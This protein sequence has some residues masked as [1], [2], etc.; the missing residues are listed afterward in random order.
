[1]VLLQVEV[2]TKTRDWWYSLKAW[3]EVVSQQV[4]L[5]RDLPE[6]L[7][8]IDNTRAW[9]WDGR[10]GH[11]LPIASSITLEMDGGVVLDALSWKAILD[12]AA[13]SRRPPVTHLFLSSTRQALHEQRARVAV[14]D[15]ATAA[16]I[17]LST[18]LDQ[19]LSASPGAVSQLVRK[20]NREL[21]RLIEV[22][23]ALEVELPNNLKPDLAQIRNDAIHGA[24]EPTVKQACI[25]YGLAKQLVERVSPRSA[26][27]R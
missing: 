10:R 13:T 4:L 26:L 2:A 22:L 25:A 6:N 11:S 9:S 8:L 23:R 19:E 27:L 16:E 20:Q 12:K 3:V 17:A 1:M 14:L 5:T 24:I 18:L 21:G 7:R 15:A